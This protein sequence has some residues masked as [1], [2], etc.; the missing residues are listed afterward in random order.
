MSRTRVIFLALCRNCEATLPGFLGM[1]QDIALDPRFEI[2][3][4]FG[5]NGSTDKTR[6]IL[7]RT[8]SSKGY[9]LIDTSFMAQIPER[10]ARMAAG[11]EAL[12]NALPTPIQ[13]D[14]IVVTDLDLKFSPRL[15][16][17]RLHDMVQELRSN[18]VSA[19]CSFSTPTFYDVLSLQQFGAKTNFALQLYRLGLKRRSLVRKIFDM[20]YL[21]Y[22]QY[23]T[24]KL[25]A[26]LGRATG[27]K[28]ISA[29]NGFCMYH[30]PFFEAASYIG[31]II[32]CEHVTLNRRIYEAT[33]LP[34][35]VSAHVGVAAPAE[36]LQSASNTL[37]RVSGNA[38]RK[39]P[40]FR[41]VSR[42]RRVNSHD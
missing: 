3:A 41:V 39:L 1:L 32:E 5:E 34:I 4:V 12:R 27:M 6:E 40:L 18:Q 13:G 26:A 8:V 17:D 2:C 38:L 16:A 42:L 37:L 33:G 24:T 20:P 36:H 15:T 19:V 30:R 31:P 7:E 22:F 9:T 28:A 25:Q 10:L 29:F 23:R 11:R 21:F 35:M 14:V